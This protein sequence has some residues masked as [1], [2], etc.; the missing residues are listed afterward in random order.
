VVLF[1]AALAVLVRGEGLLGATPIDSLFGACVGG[2]LLMPGYL[3]AKLGAGDV[4]LAAVHGVLL[5]V[6]GV[7]QALLLSALLLGLISLLVLV[8]LGLRRARGLRLPA[9]VALG[10]GFVAAMLLSQWSGA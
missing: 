2:G 8:G 5:G 10:G 3:S 1:P 7:L 9:A 6:V 4:K